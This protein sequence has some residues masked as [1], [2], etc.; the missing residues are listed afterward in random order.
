MDTKINGGYIRY[1]RERKK[2]SQETLGSEVGVTQKT[3]CK[4]EQGE[5]PERW[6][7]Y[8]RVCEALDCE[9]VDLL[10]LDKRMLYDW[11]TMKFK[12]SL[13]CNDSLEIARLS[14][15]VLDWE[16]FFT[17]GTF[18]AEDSDDDELANSSEIDQAIAIMFRKSKAET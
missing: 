2:M 11:L 7:Q 14:K 1:F 5:I 8:T 15:Q 9:H 13:L 6:R 17:T 4:W 10:T 18:F 12:E 3:I 16:R